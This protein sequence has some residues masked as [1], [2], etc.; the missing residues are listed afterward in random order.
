MNFSQRITRI[1]RP[2]DPE[3]GAD[4][5][6]H[7]PDLPLELCDLFQGT[8]GCSPYL[9][10]LMHHE[11]DWIV[12]AIHDPEDALTKCLAINWRDAD[13][14]TTLRQAKRRVALLTALADLGGVWSLENVTQALTQLADIAVDAAL[15]SA[16]LPLVNRGKL[17]G[18]SE[19][20]VEGG[21]CCHCAC[22][23]QDGGIRTKL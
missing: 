12:P 7:L 17:P 21:M 8:A 2:F 23:G 18:M 20:D 19:A 10:E 3:R 11:A 9:A 14:P 15:R 6:K 1:P 4:A 5:L 16:L 13:L 22:H